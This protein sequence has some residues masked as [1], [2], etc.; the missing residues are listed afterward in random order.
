MDNFVVY[1]VQTQQGATNV[2]LQL[3]GDRRPYRATFSEVSR[4]EPFLLN[5]AQDR[6]RPITASNFARG[7]FVADTSRWKG[8]LSI[9]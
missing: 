5:V 7:R 2:D 6:L 3:A 1:V 9:R 8:R 4:Q